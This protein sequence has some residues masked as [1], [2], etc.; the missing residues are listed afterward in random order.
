MLRSLKSESTEAG[1][2][3]SSGKSTRQTQRD[4]EKIAHV[5]KRQEFKA[6]NAR[7]SNFSKDELVAYA[8]SLCNHQSEKDLYCLVQ[9]WNRR[10]RDGIVCWF[11]TNCPDP[12]LSDLRTCSDPRSHVKS[13]PLVQPTPNPEESGRAQSDARLDDFPVDDGS[14]WEDEWYEL[15][16]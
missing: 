4:K 12:D 3:V 16:L 10:S 1:L 7:L 11:C 6:V 15:G 9:R 13:E 5:K 8:Q 14:W 2:A